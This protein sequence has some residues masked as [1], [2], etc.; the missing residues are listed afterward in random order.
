MLNFELIKAIDN[1]L[2]LIKWELPDESVLG[3]ERHEAFIKAATD[4]ENA[5]EDHP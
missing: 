5:M 3:K 2:G 4:L 1:L